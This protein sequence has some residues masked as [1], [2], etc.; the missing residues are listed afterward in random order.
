[1]IPTQV[2][3][4]LDYVV[5]AILILAPFLL[6]FADGTAAQWVPISLG[7][8]AVLYSLLTN[9]ELGFLKVLPLRVH[10]ILDQTL[11]AV[12]LTSPWLFD[13]SSRIMWPHLLFGMVSVVVPLLTK[14][15]AGALR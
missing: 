3:G 11:G 10:L 14:P 8:V 7:V 6:G 9:Y 2:H 12:L 5:G 13:F 15:P 4:V 1:M